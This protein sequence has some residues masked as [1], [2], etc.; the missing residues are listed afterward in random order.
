MAASPGDPPQYCD[1]SS[2]L[3]GDT[4]LSEEIEVLSDPERGDSRAGTRISD[5]DA[6]GLSG[7]LCTPALC[8]NDADSQDSGEIKPE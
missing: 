4:V 2:D 3:W 1:I 6:I 8:E 7:S 5:G